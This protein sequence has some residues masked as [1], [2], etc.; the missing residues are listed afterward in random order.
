M[1][2]KINYMCVQ[3]TEIT[4]KILSRIKTKYNLNLLIES[5]NLFNIKHFYNGYS[6]LLVS[7]VNNNNI[8]L[9]VLFTKGENYIILYPI[10]RTKDSNLKLSVDI[11]LNKN[12]IPYT[13]TTKKYYP[14]NKYSNINDFFSNPITN[15]LLEVANESIKTFSKKIEQYKNLLFVCTDYP[16]YGG[17]S[18]NCLDLMNYYSNINPH[19][20]YGI[21]YTLENKEESNNKYCVTNVKNLFNTITNL[22]FK[23]DLI[24][25]KNFVPKKIINLK[26]HF[27]CKIFFL[28]PG[29]FSESLDKPYIEVDTI[30]EFEYFADLNVINQIFLSDEIFCNSSH[31]QNVLYSMYGVDSN[32]FC[33]GFIKYKNYSQAIPVNIVKK[34]DYAL[35]VSNLNRPIKN[36]NAS[37]NFLSNIKKK[38]NNIK[39]VIIGKGSEKYFNY[40]FDTYYDQLSNSDILNILSN[41][42]YVIQDSFYESC[43][44][45]KLEAFFCG[46]EFINSKNIVS[47]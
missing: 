33:S 19:N 29:I 41:T 21:F 3:N 36:I 17:A 13:I 46:C 42:K 6:E 37:L 18:T 22:T 31:T 7:S 45:V 9:N 20:V 5:N 8:Q 39:I 38:D 35:I 14:D 11:C 32:L 23:P 30:T 12:K 15:N 24:I 25:L 34:Y 16:N 28:I 44:N 26:D 10:D 27:S 47:I 4:I 1:N 43:S 40:N 2:V